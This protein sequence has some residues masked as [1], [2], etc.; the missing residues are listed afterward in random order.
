MSS[1]VLT[2][3]QVNTYV[4]SILEGDPRL[5]SVY[6]TGEISNFVNHYRSGHCYLSLKDDRSA[7]KAVMFK[8]VAS[9]LR[10]VPEN[11]MKVLVQ[12]RI[13]LYERDGQYQFYIDDMQPAGIGAL[14]MALEQLKKKLHAQGLF[15][16]SRKKP[17]PSMPMK[18][19]VVTSPTG[20]AVQDI[21]NILGRRFPLAEMVL[22][23]VLVQG[24]EAPSQIA[25]ALDLINEK[26]AADVIIVGRGGGSMEDLWAFNSEQVVQA[27]A[28]SEIP[29]ISAVGHETDYT[30]CDLAADL[31]APTPSAAAELAVPQAADLLAELYSLRAIMIQSLL[32][33]IKQAK[34]RLER[35]KNSRPFQNPED[36]LLEKRMQFDQ[37]TDDMTS[38]YVHQLFT[39]RKRLAETA[40]KLDALSPLKVL[41]RGYAIPRLGDQSIRSVEEVALGDR[42]RLQLSD[43]QIDCMVTEKL[44]GG[45]KSN[46]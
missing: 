20:A 23:P 7:I 35:V 27:V 6:L 46:E 45:A 40:A 10:F 8:N 42:I 13:S 37:I 24:E 33:P 30:L 1:L 39:P 14:Q 44:P 11:G 28:R 34:H 41:A 36:I 5:Q 12:G 25:S 26:H 4:K 31:R 22:C 19:G 43:G 16:Q 2:V 29:V 17:L 32:L 18:V 9:R 21:K 3:T 15:D 38:A